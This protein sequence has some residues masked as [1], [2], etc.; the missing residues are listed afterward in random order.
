MHVREGMAAHRQRQPGKMAAGTAGDSRYLGELEKHSSVSSR[1]TSVHRA[2][3][4]AS[5]CGLRV[6]CPS[7]R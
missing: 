6:A 5:P 7:E 3:P 1:M 4:I 2:E